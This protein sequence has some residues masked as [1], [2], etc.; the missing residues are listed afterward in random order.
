MLGDEC[1]LIGRDH[2]D[3]VRCQPKRECLRE[4][5]RNDMDEN[6]GAIVEERCRILL[7]RKEGEERL[8]EPLET[9]P[10]ECVKLI[11]DGA[12][13]MLDHVPRTPEEFGGEAIGAGRLPER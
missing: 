4:Q 12:N 6:N 5:L 13:V 9:A 11:K 1:T 10:V 8:I 2:L 3:Q 7:L